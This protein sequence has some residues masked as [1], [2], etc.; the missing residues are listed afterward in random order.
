VEE[1][2]LRNMWPKARRTDLERALPKRTWYAIT[3]KAGEMGVRRLPLGLRQ[4]TKYR[5]HPIMLRIRLAREER[6][7]SR[8]DLAE[9]SGYHKQQITAWELGVNKPFLQQVCDMAE[10]VGLQVELRTADH[11]EPDQRD[12]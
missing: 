9:K 7:W 5:P 12:H 6:R 1:S 4:D 11:S 10:T 8:R 3:R 2:T